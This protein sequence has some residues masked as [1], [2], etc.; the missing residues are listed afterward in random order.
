MEG[1]LIQPS[2]STNEETVAQRTG[3]SCLDSHRESILGRF[4]RLPQLVRTICVQFSLSGSSAHK[5]PSPSPCKN[6]P[7]L[8]FDVCLVG[9]GPGDAQK[10]NP[11]P[12]K[13]SRPSELPPRFGQVSVC[14]QVSAKTPTLRPPAQS[15]PPP[16]R[17]V[18]IGGLPSRELKQAG[19]PIRRAS[20]PLRSPA[21]PASAPSNARVARVGVLAKSLRAPSRAAAPRF[22][23]PDASAGEPA[24]KAPPRFLSVT[25]RW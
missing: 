13:A 11:A 23:S 10:G 16:S 15:P 9:K 3:G 1:G 4:T 25:M 12:P 22:R 6:K 24:E 18:P 17:P 5:W 2:N 8:I 14:S 20:A 7:K 21:S 19:A